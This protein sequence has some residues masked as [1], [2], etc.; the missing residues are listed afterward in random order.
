MEDP[1]ENKIKEISKFVSVS[2]TPFAALI[3]ADQSEKS[4]IFRRQR[5]LSSLVVDF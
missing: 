2:Q 1:D 5:S 4:S 3:G